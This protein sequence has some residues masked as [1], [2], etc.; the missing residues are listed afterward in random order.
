MKQQEVK[1]P[2]F[3]PFYRRNIL[4]HFWVK[5]N[6]RL[7]FKDFNR[8]YSVLYLSILL[9]TTF[10]KNNLERHL[11]RCDSKRFCQSWVAWRWKLN[12]KSFSSLFNAKDERFFHYNWAADKVCICCKN[13]LFKLFVSFFPMNKAEHLVFSWNAET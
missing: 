6:E 1:H 12:H 13:M 10:K 2:D 9:L 11:L 7:T 8:L 3:L 4:L 5:H